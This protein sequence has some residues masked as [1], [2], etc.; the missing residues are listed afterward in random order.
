M[1][2]K[3]GV[4]G[5]RGTAQTFTLPSTASFGDKICV[6]QKGAG[7]ITIAQN[8]GQTIHWLDIDTTTG[9]TGSVTST[10][11]WSTL[12]LLCITA[13]TDWVVIDNE[14]NWDLV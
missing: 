10:L 13:N 3:Q 5:N 2:V 11:Q 12:C 9:A 7:N 4:V 6:I 8:A 1:L 14:G